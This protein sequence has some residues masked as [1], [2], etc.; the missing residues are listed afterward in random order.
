MQFQ[1]G[2]GSLFGTPLSDASGN[3][4][5]NPTP[6]KFGEIQDVS[7][8]MSRD[9]KPLYG[10]K[11][12]PVAL[13]GGKMKFDI[14]AKFARLNGRLFNDLYF[15]QTLNSGTLQGVYNDTAGAAI[16]ATPYQITPAVPS[17]GT[18]ARDLGVIDSNGVPL[19]RVASAP[20]T[21]Q[22]SVAA[23]VYTFAAADAT[24][25]VFINF[26]YTASVSGAKQVVF[27]NLPMGYVP[28]FGLDIAAVYNG[29]QANIRFNQCVSGKLG[30]APKQDDFTVADMEI[31]AFADA[32]GNIG[33][34][35]L[36]E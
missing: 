8:D 18:W 29:K 34:I 11:M 20:T 30:W 21:G 23:G 31:S 2:T 12:M 9:I 6:H 33:Y 19:Q 17:S 26:A 36:A 32:A 14:K 25:V 28:S 5:A 4:I 24:K 22:Y 15:G 3:S 13:G 35:M 27:S 10:E 1:F 7:L 16:P